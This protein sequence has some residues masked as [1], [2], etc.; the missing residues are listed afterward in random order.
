M[1]LILLFVSALLGAALKRKSRDHCLKKFEK[2]KVILP[3][4]T[5]DWQKGNLQVFAHG[6]ELFYEKPK[7]SIAGKLKSYII[8]PSEV[9]KIPYILR[10]APDEDTRDGYNWRKELERIRRPN[11]LD[12]MKRSMLNFYNMLRDAF[13]QASQA[14]LGAVSKD[15]TISKVKNSDKQINELKTGLTNLVPNAWEPVLEKSRGHRIVVERKTSQRMVKESGILEDYSSKY[16]LVRE[17]KIQDTELLDFL[18]NDSIRE[19]K[20]HDFIYNRSLSTIR[21]TVHT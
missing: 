12:K 6:L 3:V 17:V 15:S 11:F 4:Q 9:D 16:L 10:P 8:H 21:H 20:K 1:P 13:G 18:K 5:S 7:N 14:I 19:N 2:C